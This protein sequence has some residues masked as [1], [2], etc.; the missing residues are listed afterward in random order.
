MSSRRRHF[1][2]DRGGRRM[3]RARLVRDLQA[4][5][6]RPSGRFPAHPPSDCTCRL[7][8][9][10]DAAGDPGSLWGQLPI[11]G[12][13]ASWDAINRGEIFVRPA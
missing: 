13:G 12:W 2:R 1:P 3:F 6:G 7:R 9:R 11:V 8:L 10:T 5:P 4:L